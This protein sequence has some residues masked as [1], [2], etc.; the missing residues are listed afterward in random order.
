MRDRTA[1]VL[2]VVLATAGLSACGGRAEVNQ[3]A[4]GAGTAKDGGAGGSGGATTTTSTTTPSY[5]D[6]AGDGMVADAV[7]SPL[8]CDTVADGQMMQAE[9]SFV[10][11]VL[12]ITFSFKTYIEG[13]QG[14]KGTP[15]FGASQGLGTVTDVQ[16]QGDNLVVTVQS[17][18][19]FQ[20]GQLFFD[21]ELD[22]WGPPP[23]YGTVACPVKRVFQVTAADGGPPQI[24]ELAPRAPQP[25]E[26]RPKLALTLLGAEG[27]TARVRAAGLLEGA[28]V[29]LDTTGGA[30]SRDGNFLRWRLP[31][32]PGLYQLE[33]VVR[34]GG[35]IATSALAVEVRD[36]GEVEA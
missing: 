22:G 31:A 16:V 34:R 8:Q 17:F 11:D 14:W 28:D 23:T 3:G 35:A 15:T 36:E 24:A 6:A 13:S 30:V 7:P 12:T 2:T 27:L 18:P 5:Y 32:E 21:G 20:Q 19:G 9:G 29:T 26:Q 10:G 1:R 33:V 4:G 25:L